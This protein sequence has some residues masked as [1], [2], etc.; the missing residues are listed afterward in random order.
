MTVIEMLVDGADK[1]MSEGLMDDEIDDEGLFVAARTVKKIG[2]SGG[3]V[4]GV[5][6]KSYLR[7]HHRDLHC[8]SPS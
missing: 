5:N 2:Q 1:W 8:S 3:D 6:E 4:D 7:G